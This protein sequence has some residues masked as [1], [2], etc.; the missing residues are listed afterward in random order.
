MNLKQLV[1]PV[2]T[3]II[4][5]FGLLP[6]KKNKILFSAFSAR[7]FSDNP[8]YIAEEV[9]SEDINADCVFVLDH[10]PTEKLPSG[11]RVVKYNTLQ[12]LYEL[13]TSKVWVD[14]TRKQ[15][16]V[17][18][19][20]EQIYIQTWHGALPFK[21]IEKDTASLLT[22]KYIKT[23][24]NDSSMINY[25]LTS[26]RFGK[27]IFE[28]SFWYSGTILITGSPRLDILFKDNQNLKKKIQD[29]MN[30]SKEFKYVLYAPTFRDNKKNDIRD[31]NFN[32]II[33]SLSYRFGGKWKIILRLHPN[34]R[35]ESVPTGKNIINASMYPDIMDLFLISEVLIT[36]YSSTMFD[37]SLTGKPTFL[38]VPDA[39]EYLSTRSSY[40]ELK[41]LPFSVNK[42]MED[43]NKSISEFN[44]YGYS[45]DVKL[46]FK[47]LNLLEDG[48]ASK[49]VTRLIKKIIM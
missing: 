39:T 26:S 4:R 48:Q 28:Q 31:I 45:A 8:K 14:N 10:Y 18:K 33:R 36:D 15:D 29:R 1:K 43:L 30:L 42:N 6:L 3:V 5:L 35:D 11:I 38:Y 32:E 9:L 46:F 16:F 25:L 17:V 37:F 12:Y 47:N 7:S 20:D 44:S 2:L 21:K 19:R 22:D 24:K 40:F 49:R 41:D 13:A 27:E 23:A 34:V